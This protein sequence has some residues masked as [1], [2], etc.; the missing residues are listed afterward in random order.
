MATCNECESYNL[1][2]TMGSENWDYG[3]SGS[4]CFAKNTL[5]TT[6][7]ETV[8]TINDLSNS[9]YD[10]QN[11]VII[12]MDGQ[13]VHYM[14]KDVDKFFPEIQGISIYNSELKVIEKENLKPFDQLKYLYLPNNGLETISS[15][16][17]Q[18]NLQ[19]RVFIIH[20]NKLKSIGGNIFMNLKALEYVNI[21]K[22]VCID[23]LASTQSKIPGIIDTIRENC[24]TLED[25][26]EKYC[27][28][29]FRE[30]AIEIQNL[31]AKLRSYDGN[32]DAATT[33]LFMIT[34]QIVI[35]DQEKNVKI[36][37]KILD[38]KIC[39]VDLKVKFD[40]SS[41]EQVKGENSTIIDEKK[42][43]SLKIFEQQTLFLPNNLAS[44]FPQLTEVSVVDS[45]LFAI[46]STTFESMESL[47]KITIN[48]N[49]LMK[50]PAK[51]FKSLRN[52]LQLDLSFNKILI[53]EDD[54]FEGL[55]RLEEL[56][57]NDNVLKSINN[58]VLKNLKY[59]KTLDLHNNMLSFVT[60]NIIKNNAQLKSVD[61]TYNECLNMS[62]PYHNQVLIEKRIIENCIAPVELKCFF[63]DDKIFIDE[64]THV[65]GYM[66]KVVELQIEFPQTKIIKVRGDHQVN[67]DNE[68]VTSFVA[69]QQ[70]I[71]FMPI[72]LVKLLPKLEKLIV[73]RS[74]L[75]AIQGCDFDGLTDLQLMSLRFNNLSS[76][77]DGTFDE[78]VRIEY[79]NLANNII[80]S[81]PSSIFSKLTQ[82]KTLILSNNQLQ[83]LAGNI[84]PRKN[85]IEQFQVGHNH[86]ALIET[87]IF[88]SLRKTDVIE[89]NG[90]QCVDMKMDKT[91]E[92][93]QTFVELLSEVALN[94]TPDD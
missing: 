81:L 10:D 34:N 48:K 55:E 7:N 14:P 89:F 9:Q 6:K 72:S 73:E 63:S 82:L 45:G 4:V 35:E 92:G 24:P 12:R 28:E 36:I 46:D 59:L 79:L 68:N 75:T 84:L 37:C 56:K 57:I 76:I 22:N 26:K 66:C 70:S 25:L 41:I 64:V 5:I 29:D 18:F 67:H 69:L 16:L 39:N 52:L 15:N 49:R 43:S 17:F 94:C 47:M 51:S 90:N 77:G 61:L 87:K 93:G 19:L 58:Q 32:F 13:T 91:S 1:E 53:L 85:I 78:L 80:T 83:S 44:R 54:A 31:Q 71:A 88:E 60:P 40:N 27:G 23:Q 11:I 65:S 2:C 3:V 20:N 33:N 86:L 30:L 62:F 8:T 50:I 21:E 42:I 38:D 74:Q